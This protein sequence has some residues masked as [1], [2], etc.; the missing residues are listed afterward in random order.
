MFFKKRVQNQN[1]FRTSNCYLQA[2]ALQLQTHQLASV[3]L[4][5]VMTPA[6]NQKG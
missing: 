3:E 6:K 4:K 1:N 5:V 2:T